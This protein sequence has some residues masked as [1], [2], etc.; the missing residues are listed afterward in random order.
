MRKPLDAALSLAVW[1]LLS[2]AAFAC[3]DKLVLSIG[4]LRF[5]Q[6]NESPRPASILA[7]TPL[8]SRVAEVVKD[9]EQQSAGKRVGLTFYSLDDPGRLDE[10]LRAQKYDLLLV[11][12]RDA[13]NL[14]RHAQSVPSKPLVLPVVYQSSKS[15]AAEAEK[16][17]HC[18][19]TAPNSPGRYLSAI[20]RAM[21]F[22]LK[23][24]SRK[25]VP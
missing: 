22:K 5:R 14:E 20:D 19:L 25:R 18:V 7:Y 24:G 11:D 4:N 12:A 17:F 23:A 1:G 6:V 8:N 10:V 3:G 16:R 21:E 15:A 2:T 13:D 9:L